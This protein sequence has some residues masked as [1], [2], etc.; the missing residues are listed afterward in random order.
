MCCLTV[1]LRE[2]ILRVEHAEQHDA[3]IDGGPEA[4]ELEGQR[5]AGGRG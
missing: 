3:L 4:S 5:V 2:T 1:Q